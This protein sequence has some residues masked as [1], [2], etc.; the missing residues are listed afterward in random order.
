M[1]SPHVGPFRVSAR[2]FALHLMRWHHQREV[3]RWAPSR[4][5]SGHPPQDAEED[6][7]LIHQPERKAFI[8][9]SVDEWERTRYATSP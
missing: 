8:L 6:P 4:D 2:L 3:V 9:A 7:A 5:S 1:P